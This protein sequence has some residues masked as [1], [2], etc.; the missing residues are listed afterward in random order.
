MIGKRVMFR[1]E[2]A[3]EPRPVG[4]NAVESQHQ[5]ANLYFQRLVAQ[6]PRV[7]AAALKRWAGD[8]ERVKT[9]DVE[10]EQQVIVIGTLYKDMKAKPS[11]MDEMNADA[12]E[13]R[14]AREPGEKYCGEA[15]AVIMEDES[16][17]LA[18]CGAALGA[19]TLLVTGTVVGVKGALNAA[20]ELEVVDVCLPG[21]APQRPLGAAAAAEGEQWLAIVSGLHLGHPTLPML[22]TQL[23]A[24]WLGG[25]LGGADGHL[26]QKSVVRLVIAGNA[27]SNPASSAAASGGDGA[28]GADLLKRTSTVDHEA[29]AQCV[30][31]VRRCR[32]PQYKKALPADRPAPLP[33]AP[34]PPSRLPAQLDQF[35]TA[36]CA[37][38]PV[39]LMP[40]ADD[41]CSF[42]L[43]QQPFHR[44][45]LPQASQ[46][47]TLNLCTN[48]YACTVGGAD[49]LGCSGQN[50]DDLLRYVDGN[51]SRHG[52]LACSPLTSDAD[53]HAAPAARRRTGWA[54]S[55]R[56]STS[57][58]SRPPRPTRSV[59]GRTR[60][61]TRS[62]SA[63]VRTST[64]PPTSRHSTLASFADRTGRQRVRSSSPTS[65]AHRRASS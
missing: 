12:L 44:C 53:T 54:P 43:P 64:L 24:E 9:L 2:A 50:V 61:P 52:S 48:P 62:L 16:G 57:S 17:R 18:L 60:Q 14:P 51:A 45:L 55:S 56:P 3:F 8:I 13:A 4:A 6:R 59:A 29:L 28:G 5:Y 47:E 15:D 37:T 39:D 49:I 7:E 40:G 22:P 38:V 25:H 41:P 35:L 46:L 23:L 30:R 65:A 19:V 34:L 63:S 42:L 32:E 58:T 10:P 1:A 26:L 20:G 27:T 21:L 11:I 31:E 33:S 36:V